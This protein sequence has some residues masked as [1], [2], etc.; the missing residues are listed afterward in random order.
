M[1]IFVLTQAMARIVRPVLVSTL[2]AGLAAGL[3]PA[4]ATRAAPSSTRAT[5]PAAPITRAAL[6]R[7][8][9]AASPGTSMAAAAVPPAISARSS[10]SPVT[11]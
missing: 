1:D 11:C 2:L 8:T 5:L 4:S 3:S 6:C 10:S 9:S 7:S